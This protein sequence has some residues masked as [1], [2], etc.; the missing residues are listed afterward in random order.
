MVQGRFP[1]TIAWPAI[2]LPGDF[3]PLIAPGRCAFISPGDRI[4]AHGGISLEEL[5][6][7]VIHVER[8]TL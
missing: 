1:D 7:P 2:G 5:V 3:L 4:V 6:V 8:R